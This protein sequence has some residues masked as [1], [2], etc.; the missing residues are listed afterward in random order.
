M[1][2]MSGLWKQKLEGLDLELCRPPF[3]ARSGH[4][5]TIIAHLWP[6]PEPDIPG[7]RLVIDLPDGDKL[8]ADYY[9]GE[10]NRALLY[11]FHGLAGTSRSD[12]MN[13]MVR[14]GLSRGYHV[15]AVNHR[16][17]GEGRELA[18]GPYHSGRAEDLAE[19]IRHGRRLHPEK[20]H[21]AVGFSLSGNALL[22]LMARQ[23]GNVLPDFGIAVNAPIQL[24]K[25]AV[26]LKDGVNRLYDMRF[27]IKCRKA[28]NERYRLGLIP[29]HYRI[30]P[31]VTLH[32]FDN[33]YTAPEGS[34]KDREDYYATCSAKQFLDRIDRPALL[35]TSRDDPMVDYH[36]YLDAQLSPNVILRLEDHG[37]HMGYLNG[38][39]TSLGTNRWL[40]H[41]LDRYLTA[42]MSL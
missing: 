11:L 24:E 25:G 32:D 14:L 26:A 36:D 29:T 31:L 16:G 42:W 20:A 2:R 5:Q 28:V 3:W 40:D 12:Y 9:R 33:I 21:L 41:A 8:V 7:K 15:L 6:S 38:K 18:G 34:F 37:G 30:P 35:L 22:L 19:V 39:D 13:R 4:A 27:A 10:D 1:R 23:R 17:C